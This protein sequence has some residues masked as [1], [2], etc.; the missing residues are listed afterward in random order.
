[1]KFRVLRIIELPFLLILFKCPQTPFRGR[2][3]RVFLLG[4]EAVEG[5]VFLVD[6]GWEEGLQKD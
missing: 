3:V 6:L 5:V 2:I 4:D 1:L